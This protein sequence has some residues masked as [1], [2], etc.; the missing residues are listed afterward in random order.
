M[1]DDQDL[2]ILS[3]IPHAPGYTYFRELL[4][5]ADHNAYHTGGMISLRRILGIWT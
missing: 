1:I 4:L 2:E 5:I 3:E